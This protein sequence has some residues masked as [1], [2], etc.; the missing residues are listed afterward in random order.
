[1]QHHH[2]HIAAVTAEHVWP[3]A[4]PVLGVAFDGTGYGPDGAIWG[5]E[6][7]RVTSAGYRRLAHLAYVPLPG[8]DAAIRHPRRVALAHLRAAGLAWDEC[9]P[10]VAATPARERRIVA[11]QFETGLGCVPTSS[12]GRLFDAVASLLG[13]RHEA[14]YEAQAA[15]EL[16]AMAEDQS[17]DPYPMD[18]VAG[19]VLAAGPLIAALARDLR[20]GAR[21]EELAGRAHGSIVHLVLD[22]CRAARA[23][24]APATVALGGGVFQN[25]VLLAALPPLLRADGFDV[26]VPQYLPPNDGGIALGQAEVARAG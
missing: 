4:E 7:L 6:L 22:A 1:V 12:A 26:L 2:A 17:L 19:E 3:G 5:G 11:R 15:M 8:G 20:R 23:A 9:L 14:A 24:G 18:P 16:E 25:A 13:V 21:I 10:P